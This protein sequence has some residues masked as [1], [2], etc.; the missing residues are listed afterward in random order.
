[1]IEEEVYCADIAQQVNATM[2]LL[3]SVN[4]Y[5]LSYH[6]KHCGARKLLSNDKQEIDDFVKELIRVWDVS[7][8]K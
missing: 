5:L 7:T 3:K 4:N 2:G 1:M 8:R 6:I